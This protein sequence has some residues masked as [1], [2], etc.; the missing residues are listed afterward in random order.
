[1]LQE[2][3]MD[4]G[5]LADRAGHRAQ[6]LAHAR[7]ASP[8]RA[9]LGQDTDACCARSGSARNRSQAL[10][11]R[12]HR[13]RSIRMTTHPLQRGRHPRRF[14]DRTRLH[15]HRRQGRAGRRAQRMRL[16]EDR[17]DLLHLAQ[18]DPDAARRRRGDGP[19]PPRAGRGV[20]GAGA[21]PARCRA[22]HGVASRRTEP[23]DVDLRDA[24]PG[25]PAHAAREELRRRWRR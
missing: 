21:E 20:H 6:A 12:R 15:P 14:P 16:R 22:R 7:R 25:Q 24:Q 8:Q 23:R 17:G 10:K 4:D 2:I 11:E 1:M 5:E 13:Q 9:A 18:G 3:R 19:H